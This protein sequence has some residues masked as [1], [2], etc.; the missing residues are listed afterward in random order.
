[1][2]CM[3]MTLLVLSLLLYFT[4]VVNV[5]LMHRFCTLEARGT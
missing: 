1:M 3:S 4:F 5:S 2:I